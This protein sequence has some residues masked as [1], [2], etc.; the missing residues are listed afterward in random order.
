MSTNKYNTWAHEVDKRVSSTQL[1]IPAQRFVFKQGYSFSKL[2]F[3]EQLKVWDHIW[4]TSPGFLSKVQAFF[5]IE[6]FVHTKGML[7]ELWKTIQHWQDQVDS[8]GL[9]DCLS[10]VYTKVLEVIPAEVYP[11]LQ[12]WNKSG[13][14]WKRRQ[15][16]V[17]LLY[18]S[19]TKEVCLPFR[20]IKPLV[21]RLLRDEEYYVQKGVGW[22][23]RE[24]YTVYPFETQI[25]LQEHIRSISSIAF[26]AVTE[27]M[28]KEE[29]E[30]LK[31][32]RK[33]RLNARES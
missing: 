32:A 26:S 5:Y 15:S 24:M 20:K 25:L 28:D 19:S 16:V 7:P 33:P 22:A 6:Q 11:Q 29:K 8:W 14:L 31:A 4:R 2:P 21:K 10:K 23:L 1:I 27:K 12:Q 13:D 18:F 17:S 30:K 9:C 3:V